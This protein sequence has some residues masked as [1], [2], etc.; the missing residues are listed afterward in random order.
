[1]RIYTTTQTETMAT[2]LLVP[3][4]SLGEPEME[5]VK[6]YPSVRDQEIVGFGAAMTEASGYV[7]AQMDDEDKQ[8]FI[9]LCFGTEGARYSLCRTTIQSCDFSLRSRA[10]VEDASDKSLATFS[11]EEDR[12]YILPLLHD[13]LDE[14][15][16]ISF[17]ASPWSPP[18]WAKTNRSMCYGGTLRSSCAERWARMMALYVQAYRAEGINIERVTVQNEAQARQI[19]E[20]CRFS[21]EQEAVFARDFLRPALDEVGLNDVRILLWDHNKE[22]LFDRARTTMAVPGAFDAVDG[23]AFHWYSGDHFENVRATRS[24]IGNKEL[25]FTEGCEYFSNGNT[26]CELEHAEHYAHEIIGDLEAGAQGIIDWNILLD[27][28]GG[29]NHVGN[30]CDA[31]IM[32]DVGHHELNV[33]LPFWYLSHFSRF[34]RPG[35]YRMLTSS[36][37]DHLETTGFVNPDGSNICVILNRA[38]ENVDAAFVCADG[39]FASHMLYDLKCPAHSI[40][41]LVW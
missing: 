8:R 18:A 16:E 3:R 27:A 29:P 20:S 22:R 1:M 6:A 26:S 31:P 9:S 39:T 19:W 23:F 2:H 36:F 4:I 38:D 5:L 37:T 34:I 33:R 21:A 15:A 14:N 17:L 13:A 7:Y 41:T 10:Y 40:S 30:F 12:R 32:Y 25:L 11:I 28:H 35:A 24:L